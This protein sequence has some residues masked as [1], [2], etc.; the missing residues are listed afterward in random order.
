VASAP[1]TRSAAARLGPWWALL[2]LLLLAAIALAWVGTARFVERTTVSGLRYQMLRAGE[3]ASPGP[4]DLVAVHYTGR[5]PD[6]RIFDS[7][8]ATGRPA[9]FRVSQVIPGM[10]EAIQLMR[11][12]GK[13][14]IH[15]P[16][17][18][19]YGP[20]GAGAT[21]PPD[22]DLTFDVELIAIAP[23]DMAAPQPGQPG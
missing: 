9:Q 11:P 21:I 15:I 1:V 14:R 18:L 8:Y 23:P 20:T 3:G 7:S 16:S 12:G 10:T 13:A 4:S 17:K 6:G 5:L 22:T 2:A 19:A